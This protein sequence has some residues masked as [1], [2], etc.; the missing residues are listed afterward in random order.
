[1]GPR[2]GRN[3]IRLIDNQN[4]HAPQIQL[5]TVHK[6]DDGRWRP[7]NHL[8][9]RR[10]IRRIPETHAR[11]ELR[12]PVQFF[13][14]FVGLKRQLTRVAQAQRLRLLPGAVDNLHH[15]QQEGNRLP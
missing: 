3:L 13:E 15:R 9:V 2:R 10:R 7:E 12:E 11:R 8:R 1:V 4:P 14:D 5:L 6:H